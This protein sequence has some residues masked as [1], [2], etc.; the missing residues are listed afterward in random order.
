MGPDGDLAG[1]AE[2][3]H[4]LSDLTRLRLLMVLSEGERNVS[5]LV[6]RTGY[7]QP[8][9]SHH[10]GILRRS[11]VV[12]ARRSGKEVF[13]RLADP[14]AAPAGTLCVAAGAGAIVRVVPAEASQGSDPGRPQSGLE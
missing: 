2:V 5:A 12:V 7:E 6:E 8:T 1:I 14:S 3:M 11:R 9:V 10:L 13:Y 4:V